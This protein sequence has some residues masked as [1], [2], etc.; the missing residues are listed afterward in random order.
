[1]KMS[2][3]VLR[4]LKQSYLYKKPMNTVKPFLF[5]A[6][7]S[8][9]ITTNAQKTP[10]LPYQRPS[11]NVYAEAGGLCGFYSIGYQRNFYIN[12]KIDF[13]TGVFATPYVPLGHG[14]IEGPSFSPRIGIQAQAIYKAKRHEVGVGGALSYFAYFSYETLKKTS[15][16]DILFAQLTYGY[17]FPSKV[18]VGCALLEVMAVDGA[19]EFT[20]WGGL[21][22]GY[23]F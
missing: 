21:R 10:T 4:I 12:K 20:P 23:R 13:A 8:M 17:T 15:G 1:M 9:A 3:S 5:V 11:N 7:L 6:S 16:D 14:F 19:P 18:Y 22:I 2:L